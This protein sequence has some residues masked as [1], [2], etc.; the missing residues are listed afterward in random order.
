MTT[1][2]LA[3]IIVAAI[4]LQA[5]LA[6]IY[7]IWRRRRLDNNTNVSANQRTAPSE[8]VPGVTNQAS[9]RGWE[10]YK[11]FRVV[12][13]V[14]ENLAG[15]IC[16]FYMQPCE[17]MA[18]PE[19]L[20]GQYLTFKFDL[21]SA[22]SGD[23]RTV[24]RCYTL[25]DRACQDYYRISVKRVGVP[26]DQPTAPPGAVSNYLHDQVVVGDQLMVKAPSG[27]FHLNDDSS[28]PLVLIAGGIGIT[29]M[30]SIIN[31]LVEQQS[32]REIWLFYGVRNG[33]EVIM[34]TQLQR[35]SG[36][37]PNFHLHLCYSRPSEVDRL[38]SDYQHAGH[39]DIAQLRDV[40][41]LGRYLY[42]ICGPAAM[43]ESMVPGLEAL[44]V[45]ASDIHFE[46]FGPASVAKPKAPQH[47]VAPDPQAS[48][49]V[50]FS[51][52]SRSAQ[53]ANG[54]DSLLSFIEA[55]GI[56]VDSAC[57][58]GMCGSCQTRIEAGEVAYHQT[59]DADVDEGHCLLCVS[60]PQSDLKLE[61]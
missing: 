32:Q 13:R 55:E 33:H 61:L 8:P 36:K 7:G 26:A 1:G 15:D 22:Q 31:T 3:L 35:L 5:I 17:P 30:L 25:S 18:L 12:R 41:Q 14:N 44:G 50:T 4:A 37:H 52:S 29:P 27:S 40:L 47:D 48:W 9:H 43:M 23:L 2:V 19:F 34:H 20:P 45:P 6:L 11:P 24:T 60:R 49:E 21:P 59:P 38:G 54:H 16:S 53:W 51:K 46:A 42:Y 57:R 28:L 10:G 39:V 58:S 56:A